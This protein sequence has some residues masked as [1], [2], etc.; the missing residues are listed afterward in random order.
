MLDYDDDSLVTNN[1]PSSLLVPTLLSC[2]SKKR[3]DGADVL[4]AYVAG[5]ETQYHLAH[6]YDLE[7][8]VESGWH[9]TPTLGIFGVVAAT[10]N[11]LDLSPEETEHAFNIASSMPAG[12]R[13]N[14]G[15]M[16]KPLHVG[17]AA[18][19]GLTAVLL[20]SEGFTADKRAFD[21]FVSLYMGGHD[22]TRPELELEHDWLSLYDTTY[23]LKKY[24]C[25]G[26][27]H[28]AIA[29]ALELSQDYEFST[30]EIHAVTILAPEFTK[31]DLQYPN[32]SSGL[33]AKFSMEYA[34]AKALVEGE[35]VLGDF[36]DEQ[37]DNEIVEDLRQRILYEGN[38]DIPFGDFE[39][40]VEIELQCGTTLQTVCH[41]PPG[42]H[43]NPLTDSEIES[44]FMNCATQ[45]VGRTAAA[46]AL[47]QLLNLRNVS[48]VSKICDS[49][50]R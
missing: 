40:T 49:L 30:N 41:E 32:P 38:K 35:L 25:C 20:A 9:A 36:T 17:H 23:H 6:E 29:G 33:E 4:T 24:P 19:S 2:T 39:T 8:H 37:L 10:A 12:L 50:R 5:L 11:L 21:E 42:T 27:A 18:R 22:D 14:F 26:N 1:H 45:T 34:V 46:R 31:S 3:L 48:D 16:T 47:E 28:A 15:T 7:W 13:Q 43:E 44:K